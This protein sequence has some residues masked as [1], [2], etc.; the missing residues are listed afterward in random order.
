MVGASTSSE[1]ERR[2]RSGEAYRQRGA[3]RAMAKLANGNAHYGQRWRYVHDRA[4]MR[5]NSFLG[6]HAFALGTAA[7]YP[8]EC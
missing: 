1:G 4:G 5:F 2:S 6:Q 8:K 7:R 3:I